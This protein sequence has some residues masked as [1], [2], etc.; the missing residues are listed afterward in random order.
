MKNI[1]IIG[2]T[3]YTGGEL[4]RIL[5]N[6]PE[7]EIKVMTSRK[8]A[9]IKVSDLQPNLKG[10]VDIDFTESLEDTSE[11]DVVFVA[12]PHEIGRAHV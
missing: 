1:G 11:L 8:Q 2:G 4:A 7:V 10:L 12:T 3:G 5:C 6:H 9:G